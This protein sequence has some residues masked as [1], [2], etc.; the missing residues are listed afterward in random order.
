MKKTLL[1][2]LI[3]DKA[4]GTSLRN[5]NAERLLLSFFFTLMSSFQLHLNW[6]Q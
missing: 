3:G 4:S 1:S 6:F 5:A 2:Q